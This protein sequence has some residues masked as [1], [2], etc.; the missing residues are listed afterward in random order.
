MAEETFSGSVGAPSTA[1]GILPAD[2]HPSPRKSG[3][4]FGGPGNARKTAQLRLRLSRTAPSASLR[5]RRDKGHRCGPAEAR[6]LIRTYCAAPLYSSRRKPRLLGGGAGARA[7]FL[8]SA[9]AYSPQQ[10]KI[11]FPPRQAK[12]VPSGG[13]GFRPGL[14]LFRACGAHSFVPSACQVLLNG[15]VDL[16][17]RAEGIGIRSRLALVWAARF[18]PLPAF[19]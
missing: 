6:A 12:N 9:S 16:I 10:T 1:L 17:I 11:E 2:F 7:R 13:P 15:Y 14:Q 8:S 5:M 3:A 18:A 4:R 19:L